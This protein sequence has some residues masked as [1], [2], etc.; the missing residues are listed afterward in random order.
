MTKT[1]K[2]Q[3]VFLGPIAPKSD[4]LV[5]PVKEIIFCNEDRQR[6]KEQGVPA[7]GCIQQE[8][9]APSSQERAAADTKMTVALST[10][11]Y[12]DKKVAWRVT[13]FISQHHADITVGYG[14]TMEEFQG[15]TFVLKVDPTDFD[16]MEQDLPEF[17]DAMNRE[18]ETTEH[19]HQTEPTRRYDITIIVK[20][21][22]PGEFHKA[23]AMIAKRNV[24]IRSLMGGPYKPKDNAGVKVPTHNLGAI[25]IQIDVPVERADEIVADIRRDMDGEPGW[26]TTVREQVASPRR[27]SGRGKSNRRGP[28]KPVYNKADDTRGEAVGRQRAGTYIVETE[29]FGP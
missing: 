21:N 2:H 7:R 10:A 19:P 1:A 28:T 23:T 18:Y 20:K 14:T 13:G 9:I 4:Q 17:E 26:F 22:R 29:H 6:A 5:S 16:R 15:Q 3:H 27:A 24:N 8:P 12:D 25:M 11:G